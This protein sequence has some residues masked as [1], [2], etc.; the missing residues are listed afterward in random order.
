[1]KRL[2]KDLTKSLGIPA[3]KLSKYQ[4]LTK[5]DIDEALFQEYL[6]QKTPENY[7][8]AYKYYEEPLNRLIET[9]LKEREKAA[10]EP[11]NWFTRITKKVNKTAKK[12]GEKI[13]NAISSGVSA[14]SSGVSSG[15][16]ATLAIANDLYQSLKDYLPHSKE[17]GAEINK[18]N[19]L[20]RQD[21]LSNPDTQ[22]ANI[23]GVIGSSLLDLRDSTPEVANLK[24]QG[25]QKYI[26][27]LRSI[28]EDRF[29]VYSPLQKQFAS[30]GLE[31]FRNNFI[32]LYKPR[33]EED[34]IFEIK[35]D[36]EAAAPPSM[37][38]VVSPKRKKTEPLLLPPPTSAVPPHL[39][40][41]TY[42]NSQRNEGRAMSTDGKILLMTAGSRDF[43]NPELYRLDHFADKG[44]ILDLETL[45]KTKQKKYKDKWK[46][47]LLSTRRMIRGMKSWSNCI[48]QGT[49]GE[50]DF[51]VAEASST[52]LTQDSV[53][54]IYDDY[55]ET[56]IRFIEIFR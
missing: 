24:R 14:I 56:M 17:I 34:D 49:I 47:A 16:S 55:R 29:N 15:L 10:K 25:V 5:D 11:K 19:D 22:A 2:N 48:Y 32:Q 43:I 42:T 41:T 31:A 13:G 21:Q 30:A 37:A 53:E 12:T 45:S 7:D 36:E 51:I 52:A 50:N 3:R 54:M 4:F 38:L 9:T 46:E 23:V 20:D 40:P 6:K 28:A 26:D 33:F 35:A 39:A 1:M 8:P 44:P 27:L 18:V